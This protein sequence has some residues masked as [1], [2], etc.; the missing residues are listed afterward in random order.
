MIAIAIEL[1]ISWLLLH[2]INQEKLFV[3][4]IIP[5]KKS[6]YYLL[7]GLLL[8]FSFLFI[9]Y[10]SI[11]WIVG[12]PYVLNAHYTLRQFS[13]GFWFVLKGVVYEELLFRGVL[14]YLIFK[15]WGVR[16]GLI[17]SALCF[18][19]Y[20]WFSYGVLGQP[21]QMLIVLVSTGV[22][23]FLFAFAFHRSGT[24]W[25]PAVLHFGYNFTAMILFSSEKQIGAQ[26]FVKSFSRDPVRPEGIL[27]LILV[28][29][30][31]TGFPILCFLFLRKVKRKPQWQD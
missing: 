13:N 1:L 30:Y 24:I 5:P 15:K 31:Y 26:L 2:L 22:M 19:I 25:L 28:F 23:G 18:G 27:P 14:L 10:F 4:G 11:S 7:I 6:F 3:L 21:V 17:L 8:P 29:L 16:P 20:H 12:N 9:L